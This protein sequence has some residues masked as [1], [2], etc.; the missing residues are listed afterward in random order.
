MSRRPPR[1]PFPPSREVSR[2]NKAAA[3]ALLPAHATVPFKCQ[4]ITPA[5]NVPKQHG[6]RQPAGPSGNGPNNLVNTE[7]AGPVLGPPAGGEGE[8]CCP[9]GSQVCPRRADWLLGPRAPS[10][11]PQVGKAVGQ[12]LPRHLPLLVSAAL[13]TFPEHARAR[14]SWGPWDLKAFHLHSNL[15]GGWQ[16]LLFTHFTDGETEAG[17]T[18]PIWG[19]S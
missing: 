3:F 14:Q 7:R 10:P 8:P 16:V 12:T 17:A 2:P 11:G 1:P 13:Q 18:Q 19:E 4:V 6:A 9:Q 5:S 15:G